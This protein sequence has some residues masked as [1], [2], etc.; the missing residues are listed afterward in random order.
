ML[1]FFVLIYFTIA[2][3]MSLVKILRK[4]MG[5]YIFLRAHKSD[6]FLL[7][8]L[9][10]SVVDRIFGSWHV[11]LKSL[12]TSPHCSLSLTYSHH[13]LY[14]HLRDSNS[15]IIWWYISLYNTLLLD[16]EFS[17]TVTLSSWPLIPQDL[18]PYPAPGRFSAKVTLMEDMKMDELRKV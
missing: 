6:I 18:S 4:N 5:Q 3:Y 15:Y 2:W 14:L 8:V 16:N 17:R 1:E 9:T 10:N 7:S 12:S 11:K 13:S